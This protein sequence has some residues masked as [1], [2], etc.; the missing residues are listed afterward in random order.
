[1]LVLAALTQEALTSMLS[2]THKPALS[3]SL[4]RARV[5]KPSADTHRHTPLQQ[6]PWRW[7][8]QSLVLYLSIFTGAAPACPAT[9]AP[10]CAPAPANRFSSSAHHIIYIHIYIYIYI[11][12]TQTHIN[13]HPHTRKHAS[14]QAHT[15][16]HTRAHTKEIW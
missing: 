8:R 3:L 2:H 6:R 11:I 5:K 10:R 4:S 14:T 12:H 7:K 1:M 15:H 9:A 13:T 16:A